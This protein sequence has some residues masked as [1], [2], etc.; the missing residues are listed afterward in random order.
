VYR[1]LRDNGMAGEVLAPGPVETKSSSNAVV[2]F[3]LSETR[4]RSRALACPSAVHVTYVTSAPEWGQQ[5]LEE[6]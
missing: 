3:R 2:C 6:I 4:E 5:L 1:T